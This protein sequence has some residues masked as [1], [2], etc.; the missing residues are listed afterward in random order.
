MNILRQYLDPVL[1]DRE[2]GSSEILGKLQQ[3][4]IE[5]ARDP[6]L[7]REKGWQRRIL[8]LILHRL[9]HFAVLLHFV[10][11]LCA[12]DA[13]EADAAGW[14]RLI[15]NYQKRWPATGK[16][17]GRVLQQIHEL[18]APL[19]VLLHSRSGALMDL[20]GSLPASLRESWT[21]YQSISHPAR[22]G[23]AQGKILKEMGWNVK[24]IEDAVMGKMLTKCDM[25]L[26][27]CD[28]LTDSTFINKAGSM[29]LAA[30][31]RLL[32]VPLYVVADERKLINVMQADDRLLDEVLTEYP[33]DDSELKVAPLSG[34]NYYFEH[35]PNSWVRFFIFPDKAYT[36]SELK[37]RLSTVD[38]HP[39]FVELWKERGK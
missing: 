20:F 39:R 24:M 18:Q 6:A 16:A 8:A 25:A 19:S 7:A 15:R 10:N 5:V 33:R 1:N 30:A 14:I 13:F 27:G 9:G 17:C 2:S 34:I 22:E 21:L 3:T 38:F 35:V 12:S 32:K 36:P 4:L 11:A 28:V 26:I 23:L 29:P 37:E 31:A